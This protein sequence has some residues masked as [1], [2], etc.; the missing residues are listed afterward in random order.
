[1]KYFE[2]DDID[3]TVDS[4]AKVLI[5]KTKAQTVKLDEFKSIRRRHDIN[6]F[7]YQSKALQSVLSMAD[8]VARFD[9]SVLITG[10]SGVGKEVLAHYIHRNSRRVK[11]N[12]V[13]VNCSALPE[14]LLES[15]L[16]GHRAGS[17]TGATRDRAGLFEEAVD[18]TVFLDE[19]GDITQTTQL[20]L[21]GVLQ[22]KE[23]SRIGENIPRKVDVRIIAATN[24]NL[25]IEVDKGNF[26]EDLL[27]RLRVV[28]IEIPPLRE[29]KEDILPLARFFVDKLQKRLEFDKLKLDAKI[30]DYF[31]AYSWPGNIREMENSIERAAIFSEDGLIRP[32]NLPPRIMQAGAAAEP[33]KDLT[34]RSLADMEKEHIIKILKATSWN[35]TRSAQIL[36]VSPS[37]LWRK[38]KE[39]GISE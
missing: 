3:K 29:R 34:S 20:K 39:Y 13:T 19:I 9:T 15:E 18:G 17:F 14:T 11:G 23:I 36:G 28:E 27:Y 2:F 26:R 7:E 16:F 8:R 30:I 6:F 38:M 21:L 22:E 24:K 12:F 1:M 35:R 31:H 10:E 37:T 32:A 33:V 4:L 25:D 5:A